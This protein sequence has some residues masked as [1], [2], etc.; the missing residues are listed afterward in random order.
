MTSRTN[1]P[2]VT[3]PPRY[4]DSASAAG[5]GE[6]QLGV[7][8]ASSIDLKLSLPEAIAAWIILR[9]EAERHGSKYLLAVADRLY[10]PLLARGLANKQEAA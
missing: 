10:G 1:T 2:G 3:K 8:D 7:E 9:K 5:R 6:A 4:L